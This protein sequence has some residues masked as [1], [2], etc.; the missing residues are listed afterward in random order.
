M[1]ATSANQVCLPGQTGCPIDLVQ[2]VQNGEV[3]GPLLNECMS[4]NFTLTTNPQHTL[5][6]TVN[7]YELR[8]SCPYVE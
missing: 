5:S 8:Y 3:T 1:T 2:N 6:P 7:S 4:V